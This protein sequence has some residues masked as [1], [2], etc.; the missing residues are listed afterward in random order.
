MGWS[1]RVTN[2]FHGDN[3]LNKTCQYAGQDAHLKQK[4]AHFY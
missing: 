4:L 1:K 2:T 3:Q